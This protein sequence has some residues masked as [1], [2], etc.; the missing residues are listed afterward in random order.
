M[1]DRPEREHTPMDIIAGTTNYEDR[2]P[3]VT[4]NTFP[5][6]P[7]SKASTVGHDTSAEIAE[8]VSKRTRA[9]ATDPM[10]LAKL[11]ATKLRTLDADKG[12]LLLAI[13]RYQAKVKQQDEARAAFVLTLGDPVIAILKAGGSL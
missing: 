10:S 1:S 8:F 3:V 13:D 6:L 9:P 5:E 11:A 7:E 2:E 12:K 4:D